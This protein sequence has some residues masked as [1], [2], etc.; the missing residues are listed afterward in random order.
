L[1]ASKCT[2]NELHTLGFRTFGDDPISYLSPLV[3]VV[4]GIVHAGLAPA[5][6]IAGVHPNL[7][8]VAVVLVTSIF[9]FGPGVTWAFVAGVTA[10][11]L[12]GDPLGS[13]PLTYLVVAA[14]VAAGARA[15][16]AAAWPYPM[17]AAFG[18][19]LLADVVMLGVFALVGERLAGAIPME[20]LLP[21]AVLN[22]AIAGLFLLPVRFVARR[23]VLDE[24]P[25][26]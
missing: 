10:N 3:A 15:F 4:S 8:L 22:A 13:L 5:V 7:A 26:W 16:G 18:G 24:H 20:L 17:L 25:A 6:E 19:S 23:W 1:E 14:A 2:R 11:V 9:G 12:V 21:A